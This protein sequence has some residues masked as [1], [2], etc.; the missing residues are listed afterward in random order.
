MTRILLSLSLF[1][2]SFSLFSQVNTG[3][4]KD[5]IIKEN[6]LKGKQWDAWYTLDS[7][8]T[9]HIFPGC[10]NENHL[11]LSCADCSK[12]YLTVQLSIDSTG[13]LVSHKKISSIMCGDGMSIK[14]EKCLLD[15]FYFIEFPST[16]RNI[17]L[18]VKVGN[19]LKC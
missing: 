10:L 18:E 11:K 1:F 17:I 8:W 3:V 14:M 2:F 6:N 15:F 19:G 12:I 16:L 7:T 5:S 4:K 9:H 13:K